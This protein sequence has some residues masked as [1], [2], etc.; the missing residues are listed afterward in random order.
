MSDE[1]LT[2][3]EATSLG[4]DLNGAELLA[5]A[6][7][8]ADDLPDDGPKPATKKRKLRA[9]SELPQQS[10]PATKNE[11][12][13]VARD[14]RPRM[15]DP[16]WNEFVMRHF[17]DDEMDRDG[18][19]LA[20]GLRRV[21]RL[22]LGPII[23]SGPFPGG[24]F[25][26]PVLMSDNRLQP[27][28]VSYMVKILMVYPGYDQLPAYEATFADVADCYAGNTDADFARFP[29]ASASTKAEVRCL[30]KALQLRGIAAE[31]KTFVPNFESGI[32]GK[33]VPEQVNFINA[34]CRR[35]NVDALKFLSAGK[36]FKFSGDVW[37]VP[38][39]VAQSMVEALSTMENKGNVPAGL[40]GYKA[41]WAK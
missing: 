38:Y 5:D 9:L 31:E 7:Q 29:T 11:T 41:D 4:A 6:L 37:D 39:D 12:E 27:A 18:R 13:S 14:E 26:A 17:R 25:Q 34:L 21:A 20:H 3:D 33:I 35:L 15:C 36:K 24:P 32:T 16:E 19:P 28:V 30:R 10:E 22:L 23:Y 2:A 1:T 8:G 40:L